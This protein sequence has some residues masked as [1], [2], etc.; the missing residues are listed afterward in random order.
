MKKTTFNALRASAAPFALV[1][2]GVTGSI[3]VAAPAMAQDYTNIT[4]SGRIVGT[5]G[6]S[7]AGAQVTVVSNDQGFSRTATADSRG[8]YRIGQLP[9]GS[10]TF[11]V[12]A[13][14]YQTFTDSNVSLSA[15]SAANRFALAATGDSGEIV[16]TAGRVQVVDFERTTTGAVINVAELADR[17]PVA[18]DLTA[19]IKLSPGTSQGDAAFGNL[20][21]ISGSSVSENAFYINGLNITDFRKGLGSV[22]VPFNFY[23]TI[24]VKNGGFQAEF[25]RT[26]GGVVNAT[27][28]SGSNKFHGGVSVNYEPDNMQASGR[29]ELNPNSTSAPVFANNSADE[30]QRTDVVFM[31]SGPVIKDMLFFSAIYNVR[32]AVQGDGVATAFRYDRQKTTDP[33]WG[34][35]IDFVPFDGQ[36]LE[37][38]YFDTSGTTSI[39]S[40]DFDPL[41]DEISD[42]QSTELRTY[43]GENYVGRYTGNFGEWLTLSAAYGINKA[44]DSTVA[45]RNDYPTII[46]NRS[47][48]PESIGNATNVIELANDKREFYRFDADVIFEALGS[49]HIRLGYDNEKLTSDNRS[50]YTGD[51]T[52][53]YYT[54]A[55]G[56]LY[57]PAGTDYVSARTFINGGVFASQNEA[58]YI[59]DNWA[60]FGNR[61]T[62]Q[63]GLRNDRF[64]NK[65]ADGATYYAS[66]NQW[67]P[68]FGF[69]ADPFGDNRTKFY[70]SFGR[71]FLPIQSNTNI[72]LAG[73]EFDL[74][75]YNVLSGLNADNTPIIGA[76]LLFAGADNCF[77]TNVA[78]CENI[79]DG[80]ATP[81]EATVAKN[82][83]P[84]SVDEYILGV[85]HRLGS[86]IKVGLYGTYRKLNE[87][88]EDVAIDAAVNQYC[89]DNNIGIDPLVSD[90]EE[91]SSTY[92][93]FHQYVLVNPGAA[94]TI[95]LSDV[96][97]G[98][99]TVRT[100][101][102]TSEQLGYPQAKRTYKALTV[103]FDREFDGVW[104]LAGSYTWSKTEGNI[105][106]GIRSDNGQDDAGI[107]TAFDQPGLVEGAYGYLPTD[108]R[109]NFKLYGAY[110]VTPWLLLGANLAIT[111]PRRFG[112][113]GRVPRT[114]DPFAALYGAA[115]FFCNVDA[116]GEIITTGTVGNPTGSATGTGTAPT[117]TPRGSVFQSDWTKELNLTAAFKLPT[118][119]VNASL[120][121][122]VFN[123]FNTRAGLDYEERGTLGNGQPRSSFRLANAFQ[124]P[125]YVRIQLGVEF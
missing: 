66:G 118:D 123:V 33:F 24:E 19:I 112:C 68:R 42:Y 43:G 2:A 44:S 80:A 63:L 93:G 27:T 46:D 91:C 9:P 103:T 11:T 4:A 72:R 18:R 106:G 98:E 25:G 54:A 122:D 95:T 121:F 113:I 110:Q 15:D 75:R 53:Q 97:P 120:R 104:S 1:V 99:T 60:L 23:E 77:D 35:K 85:E 90:Y 40:Y 70:G 105:E 67:G 82:L 12:S 57:A 28:I 64:K 22:T 52:F 96:L 47:G 100:I 13:D 5:D 10:Y 34:G 94:S 59:Q 101:D 3:F 50:Q 119:A 79:S 65:N 45:S 56:D 69:S 73:A 115:G 16:V 89:E 86:R 111:S 41:T 38:T 36:R 26:T 92:S 87:S 7:I 117:L 108:R 125:R 6:Q 78:N 74:T 81:T 116:N 39:N 58:F 84:Q 61:V 55:S 20:A 8:T 107:T 31:L 29:N 88:L 32:N 51:V 71:Y 114:V 83:K 37:F 76:P 17:V 21:S 109:H 102:F 14:G 30:R 62:L 124:R 48:S 49:H